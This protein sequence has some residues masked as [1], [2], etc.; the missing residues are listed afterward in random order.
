MGREKYGEDHKQLKHPTLMS[1]IV[2][3]ILYHGYALSWIIVF[4]DDANADR[5]NRMKSEVCRALRFVL[6]QS[7]AW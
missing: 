3:V 2:D 5:S 6:T 1:N 4:S 7:K